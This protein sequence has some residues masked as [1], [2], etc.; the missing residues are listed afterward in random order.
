M[1]TGAGNDL[2]R[3][4]DL[5]RR[6]VCE[7]GMSETVGPLTFG[8]KDEEIFL[9]RDFA[10]HKDYSEETAIRIDQEIKR[11]VTDNYDRARSILEGK[12]NEL[13]RIAEELLVREVLSGDQVGRIIAGQAL[14]EPVAPAAPFV[15]DKPASP[16][17]ARP[18]V[19]PPLGKPLPQE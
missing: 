15:S 14:E 17:A 8:R 18:P 5:A 7:W 13:L 3:V 19:V 6:M 11:I 1:T 10:Q 12:K 4:T 9:G 16:E 2:D